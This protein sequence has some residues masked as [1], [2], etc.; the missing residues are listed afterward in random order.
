[1]SLPGPHDYEGPY[2]AGPTS[3]PMQVAHT[4]PIYQPAQYYRPAPYAHGVVQEQGQPSPY[5]QDGQNAFSPYPQEASSQIPRGSYPSA[6]GHTYRKSFST[7]QLAHG[8]WPQEQHPAQ[9]HSVYLLSDKPYVP[10]STPVRPAPTQSNSSPF[11]S[12]YVNESPMVP[13]Q[14]P[15]SFG[16]ETS[17]FPEAANAPSLSHELASYSVSATM[18]PA[19]PGKK[20]VEYSSNGSQGRLQG[21]NDHQGMP[22]Q[23]QDMFTPVQSYTG[24]GQA[25]Q[26]APLSQGP[27]P[28]AQETPVRPGPLPLVNPAQHRMLSGMSHSAIKAFNGQPMSMPA[29]PSDMFISASRLGNSNHTPNKL[30]NESY[31]A[32]DATPGK[33][34]STQSIQASQLSLSSSTSSNSVIQPQSASTTDS[35]THA[36]F[37][38]IDPMG[39]VTALNH[40]IDLSVINSAPHTPINFA[41]PRQSPAKVGLDGYVSP[42]PLQSP[43]L[44]GIQG[45]VIPT[46]PTSVPLSQEVLSGTV[47]AY[48]AH[49]PHLHQSEGQG[50]P[51][52]LKIVYA[53]G[54]MRE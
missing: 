50:S 18:T 3:N 20:G 13:G 11:P 54:D 51:R 44:Q 38:Q 33:S 32:Y 9:D 40:D 34:D 23:P 25:S 1:M 22:P 36:Y 5:L 2:F 28:L 30:A 15:Y 7:S 52:D 31:N 16:A 29:S 53:G 49:L 41:Q 8:S 48:A 35:M 46:G 43:N 17:L 47:A 26:V 19:R 42:M 27:P 39:T 14:A 4:E 12:Q 37:G 21:Q 10:T 6:M 24:A 45:Q